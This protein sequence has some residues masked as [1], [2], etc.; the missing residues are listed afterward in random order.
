MTLYI[1]PIVEGQT[2]AES[3]ERLLHRVWAELLATPDRLQVL[4]PSRGNRG[5][6]VH[7]KRP[8]LAD[9]I[10]EAHARLAQR[11]K[12][13]P[14]GRGMLLLLLDADDDCPAELGPR[15]LAA[16]KAAR[17]DADISCVLA[18]KMLENWLVAG[19]SA[20]AGVNDLP[21]ELPTRDLFE[22]RSGT[23]WLDS[24]LR[25]KDRKRK[26]DKTADAKIFVKHF[27]LQECRDNCPS[28][29][30]LCRELEARLAPAPPDPSPPE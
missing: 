8:D 27:G 9:K 29:D 2:E 16:A 19:A 30:K 21:S 22:Q 5:S 6:L 15:L 4:T 12:P 28:F 18:K 23:A 3:I 13:D 26:Y 17:S 24:Q 10:R 25:R 7:P 14:A 11:L 20:L 1:A